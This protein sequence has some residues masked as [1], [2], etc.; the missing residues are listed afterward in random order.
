M[1]L[2]AAP[3]LWSPANPVLLD[4]ELRHGGE[5]LRD[6]VGFREIRAE[7]TRILLNGEDLV[8]C[9]VCVHEDELTI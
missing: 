7:G 3:P 2:D 8:L 4:V 1:L 5:V 9:G 6:R